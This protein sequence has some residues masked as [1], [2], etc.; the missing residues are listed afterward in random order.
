MPNPQT[1]IRYSFHAFYRCKKYPDGANFGVDGCASA[2]LAKMRVIEEM[3]N[4]GWTP[5]KWWQFW[6]RDE[7]RI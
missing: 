4:D 7:T 3:K 5:P 2:A 1:T 6:R